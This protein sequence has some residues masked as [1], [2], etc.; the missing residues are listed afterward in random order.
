M[1]R[2]LTSILAICLITFGITAVSFAAIDFDN[3]NF[4]PNFTNLNI[5]N[6]ASIDGGLFIK[7][8]NLNNSKEEGLNAININSQVQFNDAIF[9][10]NGNLRISSDVSI[11]GTLDA[12]V[13]SNPNIQG[14]IN[15]DELTVEGKIKPPAGQDTVNIGQPDSINST[16]KLQVDG[17][18]QGDS[19]KARGTNLPSSSFAD[20]TRITNKFNNLLS[21]DSSTYTIY[22]DYN[23]ITN[24]KTAYC[25][26]NDIVLNCSNVVGL[27]A[28]LYMT[29]ELTNSSQH[30][31]MSVFLESGN[32]NTNTYNRVS[33]LCLDLN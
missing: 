21:L 25:R 3:S 10:D 14:D 2:K 23:N 15:I 11:I 8:L 32:N 19:L 20:I 4:S 22:S 27:G 33:A 7:S 1:N 17:Q 18:I 5:T 12:S 16:F 6:N 13:I 26:N 9:G 28:H 24:T 29:L 30:G 31:C